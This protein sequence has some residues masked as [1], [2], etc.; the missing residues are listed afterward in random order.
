MP[1]KEVLLKSNSYKIIRKSIEC[2][3]QIVLGLANNTFIETDKLLI[4][5]YGVVSESIPALLPKILKTG[6]EISE[7][8]AI[9]KDRWKN[10]CFIVLPEPKSRTGAKA[11]AKTSFDTNAHVMIE[12]ALKLYHILLKRDRIRDEKYQIYLDPL[13]SIL[14]DCL[15]SQHVKVNKFE[16]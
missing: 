15:K 7:K 2:L 6:T 8:E 11:K 9:I 10:D 1:L 5:L 3:R 4:F 12:F 16:F 13:V 14:N